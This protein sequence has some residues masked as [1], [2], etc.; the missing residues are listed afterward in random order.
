MEQDDVDDVF[1]LAMEFFRNS[2]YKDMYIDE[3]EVQN[4]VWEFALGPKTERLCLLLRDGD[5]TVGALA[6]L[7]TKQLFNKDKLAVEVIWWINPEYR[8]FKSARILRDAYEY[9]AKKMGAT[10][11]QLVALE[12]AHDKLYRRWGYAPKEKAYLKEI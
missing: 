12:D 10:S 6:G 2:P 9:W 1:S 11:I 7:I 4:L 8:S 3:S 5:T